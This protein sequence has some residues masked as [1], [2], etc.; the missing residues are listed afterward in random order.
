[1]G[2]ECS[3]RSASIN[4]LMWCSTC[5]YVSCGAVRCSGDAVAKVRGCPGSGSGASCAL[6][7]VKGTE[8]L[9]RD[10]NTGSKNKERD[11]DDGK[12]TSSS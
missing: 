1:M 12:P 10:E 3:Q 7:V 8:R 5:S 11:H 2:H 4:G 6:V 9:Q